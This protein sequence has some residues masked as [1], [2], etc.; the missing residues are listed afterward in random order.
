[1]SRIEDYPDRPSYKRPPSYRPSLSAMLMLSAGGLVLL[2]LFVLWFVIRVEIPTNRLLVLVNKTGSVL[3]DELSDE[4]GDQVVLYPELVK[5]I[6][7]KTGRDEATIREHFKG[8]QYEVRKEGRYFPNPWTREARVIN[9]TIIGQSEV[10]V[11]IRKFGKPLPYPKTVAT[12]P[13]ERGP[14]AQVLNPGRHDVN[15]LAYDVQK[16]PAILIP[17]GHVAWSRCSAGPSRASRIRTR[18]SRVRRGCSARRCRRVLSSSIRISNGSTSSIF[19]ATSMTPSATRRF[20][21]HRATVS[22]SPS[23][24]RSSGRSGP[25]GWPR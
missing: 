25:I 4:F 5:A 11:L 2:V 13:D 3:P 16:F 23:R 15:L 1:M 17:E 10:G 19:A 8:I 12:E 9:T 21:S 22:R 18:S 7:A 24:A 14:V 20:T 6:S